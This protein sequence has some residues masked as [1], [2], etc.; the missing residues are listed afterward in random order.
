[1]PGKDRR[2]ASWN[3]EI[4]FGNMARGHAHKGFGI[5]ALTILWL[6]TFLAHARNVWVPTPR[7]VG[8]LHQRSILSSQL[9]QE[10]RWSFCSVHQRMSC[11]HCKGV[12]PSL[13]LPIRKKIHC[14]LQNILSD[15]TA[16]QDNLL[17][18]DL[19]NTAWPIFFQP[20]CCHYYWM[21][22]LTL[23]I[24]MNVL[25]PGL[26]LSPW[27]SGNGM[28]DWLWIIIRIPAESVSNSMYSSCSTYSSSDKP[29]ND[30]K[31]WIKKCTC[32][33]IFVC[34]HWYSVCEYQTFQ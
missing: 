22:T 30:R 20:E 29:A 3:L 6:T 16:P 15:R 7:F 31:R 19:L 13:P 32:R 9:H 5:I 2:D 27:S 12:L 1:M 10:M 26:M 11:N 18:V 25:V 21:L 28:L 24:P 23:L 34:M 4:G 8:Y 33:S 14:S 17:L